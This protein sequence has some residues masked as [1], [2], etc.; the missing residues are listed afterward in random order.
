MIYTANDAQLS[1]LSPDTEPLLRIL[2][3]AAMYGTDRPFYQ[4][5][6]GEGGSVFSLSEGV[7]TLH[8]GEDVEE[9]ALFLEMSPEV[10]TVRTDG[11]T[12]CLLAARWGTKAEFGTVMRAENWLPC[13]PLATTF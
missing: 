4:F 6:M 8:P 1:V 5:W 9:V 10:H 12:A 11:D 13:A 2:S 7:A 3:A